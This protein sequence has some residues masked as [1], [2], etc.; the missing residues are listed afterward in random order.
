MLRNDVPYG[1]VILLKLYTSRKTE[2]DWLC[3][4]FILI[5]RY[6][7]GYS[8]S[9]EGIRKEFLFYQ[10]WYLMVCDPGSNVKPKQLTQFKMSRR[11]SAVV[12]ALDCRAGGRGFDSRGRTNT[13]GLKIT[14]K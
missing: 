2:K 13:Q 4:G 6:V 14:E 10:K 1:Y 12:R 11:I 5:S 3:W 7:E 8:F 9:K